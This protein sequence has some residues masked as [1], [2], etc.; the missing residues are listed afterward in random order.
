M[1]FQDVAFLY[2]PADFYSTFIT[3]SVEVNALGQTHV[4]GLWL[5]VSNG[6]L[7]VKFF[8]SSKASFCVC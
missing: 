8:F 4:L 6:M 3:N 1:R 2:A 7:L 5:R